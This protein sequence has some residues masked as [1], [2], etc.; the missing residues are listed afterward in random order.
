M[1]TVLIPV[2][3]VLRYIVHLCKQ[4]KKDEEIIM[5]LILLDYKD[6]R[7]IYEQVK[8]KLEELILLGVFNESDPLPSVRSLA[9]EL[10]VNPNTI[11]RTYTE[12]EREGWIVTIK[13]R[14]S[15]VSNVNVK[16]MET[17]KNWTSD[18]VKLVDEG[19]KIGISKEKMIELIE[20]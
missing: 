18:F 13:G 19:I 20:K 17:E 7:P 5:A 3:T 15:F 10:S 11:Q 14:G 6:R 2:I 9:S 12:L 8:S 4:L 16:K 1:T